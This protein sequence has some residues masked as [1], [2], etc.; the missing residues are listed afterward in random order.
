MPSDRSDA[1]TD[2]AALCR[3]LGAFPTGV[4]AVAALV[5]RAPTGLAA[6]SFVSVSLDPPLVS[7]CVRRGSRTWPALRDVERLGLSV[8]GA[9]QERVSRQLSAVAGNRF[10]GLTWRATPAGAVILRGAGAWF[11]CAVEQL[12]DAGDHELV[13]LRV[14]ACDSDPRVPPLV[15][16]G[17]AYRR[18]EPGRHPG[19]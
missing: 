3:V 5:D 14:G 12:V 8:L 11:D 7:F 1:G 19:L 16:H 17:S 13:L 9:H 15:L 4:V 6:S 18:L 2:R 10:A